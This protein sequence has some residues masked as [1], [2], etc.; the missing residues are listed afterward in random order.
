VARSTKQFDMNE[1]D[2]Y[3]VIECFLKQKGFKIPK[4]GKRPRIKEGN[5]EEH[6]G[7]K[8]IAFDVLGFR[9][10]IIWLVECKMPIT[11][12]KFGFSLGQLLCYKYLVEKKYLSEMENVYDLP[13]EV[14]GFLYSIALIETLENKYKIQNNCEF[15]ENI[16]DESNLAF[17]LILVRDN[18][19]LEEIREPQLLIM[20]HMAK[21]RSVRA[22]AEYV[23]LSTFKTPPRV[24]NIRCP[25]CGS[26]DVSLSGT[27]KERLKEHTAWI[28]CRKC[29]HEWKV[30]LL[31]VDVGFKV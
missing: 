17:G 8:Y 22:P 14:I 26:N 1:R 3:P 13:G 16:L 11:V 10:G 27:M 24:V 4:Q 6:L 12:E 5:M 31:K 23:Q 2:V 9:D 19:K 28:R 25:G 15:F 29:G 21:G 7:Q 30:G 18:N 20:K